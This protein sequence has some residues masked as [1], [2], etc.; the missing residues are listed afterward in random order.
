MSRSVLQGEWCG[1]PHA[2]AHRASALGAHDNGHGDEHD[3]HDRAD[4]MRTD[5][6]APPGREWPSG[7]PYGAG[8]RS[9][10]ADSKISPLYRPG[11]ELNRIPLQR[12]SNGLRQRRIQQGAAI[13]WAWSDA[14]GWRRPC[15]KS[16]AG[17]CAN[18]HP[19]YL[20]NAK[21]APASVRAFLSAAVSLYPSLRGAFDGGNQLSEADHG[22][23]YWRGDCCF[24]PCRLLRLETRQTINPYQQTKKAP[25]PRGGAFFLTRITLSYRNG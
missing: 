21:L 17:S 11:Y 2:P 3:H 25:R 4:V 16:F 6:R 5:A 10:I 12:R 7:A 15:H 8:R 22:I 19:A 14:R 13:H 9:P 1:A 23:C 18:E 20:P 24:V